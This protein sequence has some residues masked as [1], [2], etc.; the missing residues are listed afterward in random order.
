MAKR[1]KK[2]SHLGWIV[3]ALILIAGISAVFLGKDYIISGVKEK[4]VKELSK[5][6]IKFQMEQQISVGEKSVNVSEIINHMEKEDVQAVTDIAEKYV[7]TENIQDAV[8][9]VK[10]GDVSDLQEYAKENLTEQD[11]QELQDIYEKYKN[12]IPVN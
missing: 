12:Q 10:D 9:M 3:T 8:D 7:S 5:Q 1:R 2:K 11:I 6:L 4:A